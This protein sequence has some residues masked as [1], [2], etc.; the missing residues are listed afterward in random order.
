MFNND[1]EENKLC[2]SCIL[3]SLLAVGFLSL[4]IPSSK[5]FV[6]IVTFIVIMSIVFYISW[7]FG[8]L[9]A[10][11]WKTTKVQTKLFKIEEKINE[12]EKSG[13]IVYELNTFLNNVKLNKK[14]N[15]LDKILMKINNMENR[16]DDYERLYSQYT[17]LVENHAEIIYTYFKNESAHIER[18]FEKTILNL[19]NYQLKTELIKFKREIEKIVEN[20]KDGYI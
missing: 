11:R 15:S 14:V 5:P 8:F 7:K 20:K 19:D 9:D 12:L 4:A 3:L 13:V 6:R 1:E 18:L 17:T 16:F 2:G 10:I